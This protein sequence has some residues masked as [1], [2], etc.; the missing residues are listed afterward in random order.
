MQSLYILGFFPPLTMHKPHMY[1]HVLEDKHMLTPT[2]H[3][4]KCCVLY[5]KFGILKPRK[6]WLKSS[7][8]Y[9]IKHARPLHGFGCGYLQMTH[10][11]WPGSPGGPSLHK[12]AFLRIPLTPSKCQLQSTCLLS[13]WIRHSFSRIQYLFL[14]QGLNEPGRWKC[15]CGK[16][17]RR[18]SIQ[19]MNPW[20]DGLWLG[21]WGPTQSRSKKEDV[22]LI[23]NL[24]SCQYPV[25]C[26]F[27]CGMSRVSQIP[28][29]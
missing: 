8:H 9:F 24:I 29:S 19:T 27:R 12:E 23:N 6:Y 5:I 3:F 2:V 21:Q 1:T 18:L 4:V 26:I 25:R 10:H 7:T 22:L 20:Q 14:R 16:Y 28:V 11:C 15:K 17:I 13:S